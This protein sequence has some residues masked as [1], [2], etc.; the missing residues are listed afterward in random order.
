[1]L[2]VEGEVDGDTAGNVACDGPVGRALQGMGALLLLDAA[3]GYRDEWL[4]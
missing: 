1:M 2:L 4:S 3:R